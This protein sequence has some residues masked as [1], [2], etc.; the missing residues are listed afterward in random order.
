MLDHNKNFCYN[1]SIKQ[2]RSVGVRILL[3]RLEVTSWSLVLAARIQA[4]PRL[5]RSPLVLPIK[6]LLFI[7]VSK[8]TVG[9]S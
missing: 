5:A 8:I 1:N 3:R 7:S 2:E 4:I 6:E 9:A